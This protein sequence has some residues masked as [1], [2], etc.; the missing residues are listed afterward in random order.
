MASD[1]T[2]FKEAAAPG[3]M[4]HTFTGIVSTFPNESIHVI[5]HK[6]MA[7]RKE[8]VK[9]REFQAET[10]WDDQLLLFVHSFLQNIG[11]EI[12]EVTY[13][14]KWAP[15]TLLAER[16]KVQNEFR[17][18]A[19]SKT[20]TVEDLANMMEA[21]HSDEMLVA[22]SPVMYTVTFDYTGE[23]ADYPQPTPARIPN[24]T[25]RAFI[26]GLDHF[27]VSM[28]QSNSAWMP[29]TIN[30]HEAAMFQAQ[31]AD[32]FKLAAIR[33]GTDSL[34][35]IPTSVDRSQQ[36]RLWNADGAFDPPL[37]SGGLQGGASGS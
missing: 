22:A 31:L 3:K 1:P 5:I 12:D 30:Q 2:V 35:H 26:V 27:V 8:L 14:R 21:T 10:A 19:V 4:R 7:Y 34:P 37:T 32:L 16:Q 25:A 24:E 23:N 15:G 9:R 33:G 29:R 20:T 36:D 17:E 6:I 18:K 11:K 13:H 28:T